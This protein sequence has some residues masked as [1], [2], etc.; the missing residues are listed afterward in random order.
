MIKL[1]L[2][3]PIVIVAVYAAHSGIKYTRMISHIFLS[4]VYHPL[5]E[6]FSPP[7]GER[8]GILDSADR[9]IGALFV[10]KKSSNLLVIFCAESGADKEP[11]EK[12]AYFLPAMGFNV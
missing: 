9:E 12:Y 8:I 11:W 6:L 4:L 10:E 1:L 7:R 2:L 3:F 5:P